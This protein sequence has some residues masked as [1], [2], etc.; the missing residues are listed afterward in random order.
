MGN[1][2]SYC[3]HGM[4][5]AVDEGTERDAKSK[6]R[7]ARSYS[8]TEKIVKNTAL[9]RRIE[10]LPTALPDELKIPSNERG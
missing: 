7:N 5:N 6:R 10:Y 1:N 9:L 2:V 8:N 4:T 3:T